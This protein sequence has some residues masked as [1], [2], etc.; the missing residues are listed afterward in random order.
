T[1]SVSSTPWTEVSIDGRAAGNTPLV[2]VPTPAGRHEVRLVNREKRI[3]R[4]L[5]VDVPAGGEAREQVRFGKGTVSFIALPWASV[6][7][8]GR[9]LG[10]T[11]LPPQE[12]YEGS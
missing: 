5:S 1:L 4:R 3:D 11:P 8:D 10:T 9:A 7:V 12:L 2:R 6:A